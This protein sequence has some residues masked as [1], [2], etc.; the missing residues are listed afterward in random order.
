[1]FKVVLDT[2]TTG[3]LAGDT[4]VIQLAYLV[5]NPVS[6]QIV[7]AENFFINYPELTYMPEGAYNVH[8]ISIDFLRQ[9]GLPPCEV[10]DKAYKDLQS[11]FGIGHNIDA[12]DYPFISRLYNYCGYPDFS[13]HR[14]YDTLT[15]SK[16]QYPG[17]KHRLGDML[18]RCGISTSLVDIITQ[19]VFPGHQSQGAH[20]ACWD[21]VATYFL[22]GKVGALNVE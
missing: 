3:F 18:N 16:I 4:K 9:N 2:E 20:D 14:T 8:H 17:G 22:A 15:L 19:S 5:Y 21:V 11:S 1:M 12:F 13:F 10:A 6:N 7:K